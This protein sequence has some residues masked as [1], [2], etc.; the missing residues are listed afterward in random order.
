MPVVD[1]NFGVYVQWTLSNPTEDRTAVYTN[2][3]EPENIVCASVRTDFH[4]PWTIAHQ[5]LLRGLFQAR[6]LK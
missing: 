4:T 5:P 2:V 1:K 3:M 6:T